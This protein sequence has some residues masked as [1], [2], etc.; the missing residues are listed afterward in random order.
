[1][2]EILTATE[3]RIF[4]LLS[5]GKPHTKEEVHTCLNDELS[6]V[7]AI[8]NH[9]SR[10]RKQLRHHA[11]DILCRYGGGKTTYQLIRLTHSPNDGVAG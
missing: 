1:M 11:K 5:D 4:N 10:M 8:A 6:P 3:Q 7:S 9:I 2:A